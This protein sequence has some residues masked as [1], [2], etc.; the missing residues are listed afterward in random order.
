MKSLRFIFALA[1]LSLLNSLAPAGAVQEPVPDPDTVMRRVRDAAQLDYELQANFTYL[2]QRRDV[3]ISKLGTVTVGP[4][5]TFEVYP[6]RGT[7][8][9]YKRLIAIDGKPLPPAE[10][11]RRDAEHKK[12]LR[13]EAEKRRR[14]TPALRKAREA[15]EARERQE[16]EAI[17][18][19][20]FAAF[21]LIFVGRER[22][23]GERVMVFDVRPRSQADVKTREGRWMKHFGG[24]VWIGEKDYVVAKLDMQALEDVMIG[25]GIIGRLHAGSRYMFARQ[26][27][28]GTWLPAE[29]KFDA[30][31]RTLL[32]RR[33]QVQT[34]TTFT[35][36][37]R[38]HEQ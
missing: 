12:H 17:L 32:F 5:R 29:V 8:G 30:S 4:L 1:A 2:E 19:D 6:S 18:N 9:T 25:W 20:A 23:E 13:E 16:H 35:G 24:R 14:E 11:A 28:E 10:L 22:L 33:W 31:G 34:V 15:A 21:Q 26:K 37:K 3:K 27:F 7:G 38:L 36:Y